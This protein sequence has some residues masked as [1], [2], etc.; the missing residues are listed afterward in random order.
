MSARRLALAGLLVL[1][2]SSPSAAQGGRAPVRISVQVTRPCRV[3]TATAQVSVNCGRPQL[4]E[5]RH[6][7]S[8]PTLRSVGAATGVA[9]SSARSVTIDF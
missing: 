4:V 6:D 2:G 1:L 8:S 7:R 3:S 9:P 5:V